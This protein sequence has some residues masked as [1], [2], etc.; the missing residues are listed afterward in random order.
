MTMQTIQIAPVQKTVVVNAAQAK[1]FDV[2]VNGIDRWWP[3]SHGIGSAPMV[4]SII[5][6]RQ[7]GRW[8][9]THADGSEAISGHV[10]VWDPPHRVVFSWEISA[11]WKPDA[12]VASEVEVRFIAE[13]PDRTRV[14]LDHRN[15]EALGKEGGEAMRGAVN[16]GWPGILDLFKAEAE[17]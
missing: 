4:K 17:R 10:Q 6:P 11:Q 5:E 13:T 2:F 7:G 8:Y 14:E 1:A 3:K 9:S 12:S 16:G 15:F